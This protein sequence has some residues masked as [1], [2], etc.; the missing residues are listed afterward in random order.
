[1][2]DNECITEE[3]WN[4]ITNV[5]LLVP[6]HSARKA[7][8]TSTMW[9]VVFV[10]I[11][12]T[13]RHIP[14]EYLIKHGLHD[15]FKGMDFTSIGILLMN[16]PYDVARLR[17]NNTTLS[18]WFIGVYCVI[19]NVGFFLTPSFPWAIAPWYY[20][21]PVIVCIAKGFHFALYKSSNGET[22]LL[23]LLCILIRMSEQKSVASTFGF[24]EG[25][26]TC[27]P[28]HGMWHIAAACLLSHVITRI[29]RLI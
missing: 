15:T 29:D 23:L 3:W 1:M 27:I 13:L 24:H 17:G 9:C 28:D 21:I 8:M 19:A 11:S 5:A 10:L 4:T 22:I 16:L 12:S 7:S 26:T 2:D 14:R 6:A 25:G 20:A 18:F